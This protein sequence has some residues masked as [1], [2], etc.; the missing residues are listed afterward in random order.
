MTQEQIKAL[1]FLM[2]SGALK[3]EG[4][5]RRFF[6]G[7]GM[8]STAKQAD[9]LAD[10]SPIVLA[11]AAIGTMVQCDEFAKFSAFLELV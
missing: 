2:D 10:V 9:W 4:I 3:N 8:T 7:I 5:M 11:T 6:A 1:S